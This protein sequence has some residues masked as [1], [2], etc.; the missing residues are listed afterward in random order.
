MS[1]YDIRA[2][3]TIVHNI[4][5]NFLTLCHFLHLFPKTN[6]YT[7]PNNVKIFPHKILVFGW[8]LFWKVKLLILYFQSNATL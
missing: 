1:M 6:K 8:K 4:N 7:L 2:D 5:K 3:I